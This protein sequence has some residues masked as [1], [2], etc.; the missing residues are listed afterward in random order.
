RQGEKYA[1]WPNY[2]FD[3]CVSDSIQGITH[4]LRSKEYELRDELYYFILDKLGL[5]KPV[6]YDFSRLS[7]KGNALSKRLLKPFVEEKKVSGWD[8]PRLLTLRGLKRRGI[9]PEAIKKF[10]LSFGLSKVESNPSLE[11][12]LKDN[13]SLLEPVAEH[14]FFVPKPVK[15]LVKNSKET[16]AKIPKHPSDKEKGY[17]VLHAQKDFFL[18]KKDADVLEKGETFRLKE[19]YNVTLLEKSPNGLVCEY[20]G[21]ELKENTKKLQWVPAENAVACELVIVG[22]LLEGEEL[23]K[24]SLVVE[25]GFCEEE[26]KKLAE[27]TVIQFERVGFARLDDSKKMR[28]ILST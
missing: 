4:S 20:A 21:K 19:L 18:S 5:R 3:V 9:L 27:G 8:D 16:F 6:L 7:I 17:R 12:L 28:F 13:Q 26:C 23:N 2:D 1:V 25:S 11:A 14:Y 24:K 10:V 15:V 22:D